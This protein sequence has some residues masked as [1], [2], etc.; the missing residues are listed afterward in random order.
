[1]LFELKSTN[2]C[3]CGDLT[4]KVTM[5]REGH[6]PVSSFKICNKQLAVPCFRNHGDIFYPSLKRVLKLNS[7]YEVVLCKMTELWELFKLTCL[8]PN[9]LSHRPNLKGCTV[10]T[11]REFIYKSHFCNQTKINKTK[12]YLTH[13]LACT[14]SEALFTREMNCGSS[15]LSDSCFATIRTRFAN[16]YK[17]IYKCFKYKSNVNIQTS[18][19]LPFVKIQTTITTEV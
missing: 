5:L 2:C 13:L 3:Y 6:F 11:S 12:N 7:I 14:W 4:R 18:T 19:R 9:V 10:E 16:L 15:E 8:S 1:M 17:H